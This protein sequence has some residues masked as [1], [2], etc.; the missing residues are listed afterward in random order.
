MRNQQRTAQPLVYSVRGA[1]AASDGAVSR[2]RLYELIKSRAVDS[3]KEGRRR[4][5]FGP[6]Y[7]RYLASRKS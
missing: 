1:V 4:I 2:S 7:R 5:I 3:R 6:S